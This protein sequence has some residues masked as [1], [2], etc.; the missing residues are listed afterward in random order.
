MK[1]EL[2]F[3]NLID[4][5]M[6]MSDA[7]ISVL[8]AALGDR[9]ALMSTILDSPNYALWRELT[10]IGL[11]SEEKSYHTERAEE[12]RFFSIRREGLPRLERLLS[13]FKH[14]KGYR[15]MNEVF[16]TLCVP[17]GKQI[18]ERVYGAGGDNSEVQILMGLMLAS[19]LNKCVSPKDY[20]RS[21]EQVA[22]LAKKRLASRELR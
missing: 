2:L 22:D 11:L 17:F 13:E 21:V 5:M 12:M 9:G 16:E 20:D 14:R 6:Q 19:V 10:R 7:D 3:A 15:R 1:D 18:V 4:S 8:E